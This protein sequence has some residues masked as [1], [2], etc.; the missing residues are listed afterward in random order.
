MPN[1]KHNEAIGSMLLLSAWF[2]WRAWYD[3]KKPDD[4]A[5]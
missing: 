4:P 3:S 5:K 1:Y 2:H